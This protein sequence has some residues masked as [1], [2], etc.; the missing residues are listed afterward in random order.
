MSVLVVTF[1]SDNTAYFDKAME[2]RNLV[3]EN[4]LIYPPQFKKD[5]LEEMSDHFLLFANEIA[6]GTC[7]TRII[8]ENCMRIEKFAILKDY[9]SKGYGI[10]MISEIEKFSKSKGCSKMV[11]FSPRTLEN[12]FIRLGFTPEEASAVSQ[13]NYEC[14]KMLKPVK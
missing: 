5:D 12:Y 2:I 1:S 11:F 8:E 6:V 3:F 7:R 4:E 13:N 10:F 14:I 9:R